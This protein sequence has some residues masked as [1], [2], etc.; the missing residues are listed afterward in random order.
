MGAST[1]R[2]AA[3]AARETLQEAVSAAHPSHTPTSPSVNP[4]TLPLAARPLAP[5][6]DEVVT[7]MDARDRQVADRMRNIKFEN[8]GR[9]NESS[10]FEVEPHNDLVTVVRSRARR[11]SLSTPRLPEPPT[12][13]STIKPTTKSSSQTSGRLLATELESLLTQRRKLRPGPNAWTL[14]ELA[15][16]N[17]VGVEDAEILLRYLGAAE[18]EGVRE[19]GKPP[20]AKWG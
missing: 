18:I 12:S 13:S 6:I 16:R 17:G 5:E 4:S 11:A 7:E 3:R 10:A 8:V 15:R 19:P 14:E 20:L 1:S 9:V 2:T